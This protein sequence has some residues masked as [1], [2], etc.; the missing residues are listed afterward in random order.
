MP[1]KEGEGPSVC[2]R[3]LRMPM[4][5]LKVFELFTIIFSS[6]TSVFPSKQQNSTKVPKY[7]VYTKLHRKKPRTT[8]AG[9]PVKIPNLQCLLVNL[10]ETPV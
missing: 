4:E 6:E 5:F 2:K 3:N 1:N 10:S 9:S 8:Q 7:F